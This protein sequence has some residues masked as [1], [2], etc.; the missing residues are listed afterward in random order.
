MKVPSTFRPRLMQELCQAFG[1]IQINGLQN[2][3]CKLCKI[4]RHFHGKLRVLTTGHHCWSWL[5]PPFET[6]GFNNGKVPNRVIRMRT[7]GDMNG[8]RV[9]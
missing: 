8:W 5:E 6:A 3:K 9:S 4:F 1:A 7:I 2:A